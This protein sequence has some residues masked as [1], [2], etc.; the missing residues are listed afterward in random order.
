MMRAVDVATGSTLWTSNGQPSYGDL[1]AVGDGIVAVVDDETWS[2]L[3]AYDIATGDERWHAP[4]MSNGQPQLIS[5]TSIVLLWESDLAVVSTT[6]GIQMWSATQPLRS[7]LMNSVG[8]N[9]THVFV[10]VNSLPW[11]D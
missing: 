10:A 2:E 3:V 5:G 8:S 7:P 6:D 11:S 1:W 4:R 9:T